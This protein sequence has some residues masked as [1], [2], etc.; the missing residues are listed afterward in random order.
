M[1]TIHYPGSSR[2][3]GGLVAEAMTVP[4]DEGPQKKLLVIVPLSVGDIR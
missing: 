3:A 4:F 1:K 2:Q